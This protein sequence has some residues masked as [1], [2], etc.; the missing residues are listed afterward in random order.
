MV[1]G[2]EIVP[3]RYGLCDECKIEINDNYCLRCGRHKVGVSDYC[4]D[5][6]DLSLHFDEA[7]SAVNYEGNAKSLVHR[8]KFGNAAYLAHIISEYLLDVL[9]LSDWEADCITFVPLHKIGRKKRGYNQA[10]LIAASLA[11]RINLPCVDLLEK[12]RITPNQARLNREQRLENIKG[13]F[14]VKQKPPERIILIDDVLTTAS[15]ADECSKM[16]KKSGARVVYVLTFASVPERP[17]LDAPQKN[18][19]EFRR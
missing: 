6:A 1:C 13:A 10:E 5:C 18:I 12:I 3:G 17:V 2:R 4:G 15:T 11:E 19:H 9:L 8:L 14:S 7:R 16:L